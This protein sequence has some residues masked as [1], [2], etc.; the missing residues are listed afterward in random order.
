M[1]RSAAG[2]NQI[3][4]IIWIIPSLLLSIML[5]GHLSAASSERAVR[6]RQ[7]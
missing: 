5:E 4:L 1:L 6:T 7:K 3:L 2:K